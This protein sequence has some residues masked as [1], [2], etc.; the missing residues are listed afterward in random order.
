MKKN[1]NLEQAV[2]KNQECI[3]KV[4]GILSDGNGVG[5]TENNFTIFV[6]QVAIGDVVK[7]RIAKVQKNFAYGVLLEIIE[8]SEDRIE[9]DCPV[10]KQCGGCSFRHISYESELK[11]KEDFVKYNLKKIANIDLDDDSSKVISDKIL[12]S[13]IEKYYRN[14][15]Q[16]PV[17]EVMVGEKRKILIGFYA[18]RSHRVIENDGCL[19]QPE[20]FSQIVDIFKSFIL[21]YNISCYDEK[22]HKG[23]VRHLY[24]RYAEKTN[25]V[26]VCIVIN[27]RRLPCAEVLIGTLT[28]KFPNIKSVMLNDN[29]EKSN[30]ILSNKLTKIYGESYITDVLCDLKFKISPLSFYQVNRS[31]T[32][33][34]YNI[35]RKFAGLTGNE[36]VLDLYCGVG[37]IGLSMASEAK[38]IIGVEI[39]PDAIENA[40]QN[41]VE[42]NINNAEFICSDAKKVSEALK[43]ENIT[44]DV[45]VL[46][47][48][49]KGCD[50]EVLDIVANMNPQKIVMISCNSA[51]MAR[52]IKILIQKGYT[53]NKLAPVDLF[54]RTVHVETVVLMSRV[55]K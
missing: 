34:L 32:E 49:R 45:V 16:Y 48:P 9:S 40:K 7:V 31:S 19:L 22:S 42:N 38:K 10:H 14:K 27:G 15:A 28:E 55:D 8:F 4:T 44:P 51:T 33:N 18:N 37:T 26:M 1:K 47:P 43:E 20:F 25:E 52:D 41:A 6:P 53:L 23:L 13:P 35:A 2:Y 17:Q 29:R 24:I 36:L 39:V 46:D 12:A 21:K 3:V 5:K 54:P 50:P 11:I 30:V